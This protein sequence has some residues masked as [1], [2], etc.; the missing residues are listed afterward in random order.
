M[1]QTAASGGM[2]ILKRYLMV[3]PILA[4]YV[5]AKRPTALAP[6]GGVSMAVER[7]AHATP[8][9]PDWA[10]GRCPALFAAKPMVFA[11]R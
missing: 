4:A 3:R 2:P 10:G 6:G 7:T 11:G 8:Y 1:P 9:A 5:F